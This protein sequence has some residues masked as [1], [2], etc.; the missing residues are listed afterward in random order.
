[1]L[2]QRF[3]ASIGDGAVAQRHMFQRRPIYVS[4]NIYEGVAYVLVAVLMVFYKSVKIFIYLVS[5]WLA[6][7]VFSL[8]LT[9]LI[10]LLG[11]IY[12][13]TSLFIFP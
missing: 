11:A 3:H 4:K 13:P 6:F 9:Y 5:N 1:M 12:E 2:Q 7:G 8:F 10:K